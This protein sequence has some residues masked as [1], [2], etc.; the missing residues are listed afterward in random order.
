[1]DA[2][3]V[4][5]TPADRSMDGCYMRAKERY[6]A[7][8]SNTTETH[9]P[10]C[11]IWIA[12]TVDG[13]YHGLFLV[14]LTV[15]GTYHGLFLVALCHARSFLFLSTLKMMALSSFRSL[16]LAE[17]MNIASI[18]QASQATRSPTYHT[19]TGSCFMPCIVCTHCPGQHRKYLPL[20]SVYAV[21]FVVFYRLVMTCHN[22]FSERWVCTNESERQRQRDNTHPPHRS[23][24]LLLMFWAPPAFL[25]TPTF[26]P[27]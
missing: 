20:L 23:E 22:T 1:M 8:Q 17:T 4:H 12:L 24:C 19:R 3:T 2:T 21:M 14:A 7:E 6:L 16:R 15:D 13:T 25:S 5:Q 27:V 11:F 18:P 26:I 9:F 10:M